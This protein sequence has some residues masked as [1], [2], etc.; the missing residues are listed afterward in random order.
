MV[1]SVT[2]P[3]LCHLHLLWENWWRTKNTTRIWLLLGLTLHDHHNHTCVWTWQDSTKVASRLIRACEIQACLESG[4]ALG[5]T[6]RPRYTWCCTRNPKYWVS[7]L[8]GTSPVSV[9]PSYSRQER[10][11]Y[12]KLTIN[13]LHMTDSTDL[14]VKTNPSTRIFALPEETSME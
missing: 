12:C 3:I 2:S 4:F 6:K 10:F 11:F 1:I 5:T 8:E 13:V 9:S 14:M 7:V